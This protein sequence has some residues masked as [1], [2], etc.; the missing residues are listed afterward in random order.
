[1]EYSCYENVV[2]S[3][4][5]CLLGLYKTRQDTFKICIM[6]SISRFWSRYYKDTW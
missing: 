2:G 5:C 3:D 1:V 6:F 4:V